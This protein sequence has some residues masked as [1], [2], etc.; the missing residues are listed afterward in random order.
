MPKT[1]VVIDLDEELAASLEAA[2]KHSR[3]S[4][5][6]FATKAVARAIADIEACGRG[7]GIR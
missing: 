2:A 5:E 4:I 3:T 6:S 7:S 1:R